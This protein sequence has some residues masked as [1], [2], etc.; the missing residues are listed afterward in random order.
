VAM[1]W[2]PPWERNER[3]ACRVAFD[4]DVE[5]YD[6]ARP[7]PPARV[8]DDLLELAGLQAGSS[9]VEIGPG[10]GQATRPLAMR[11]L[12]I[13]ALELGPQLAARAREN[14]ASFA[15][16]EVLTT[17]FEA[18]DPGSTRVAAVFA[19][20]S[21]HWV[22]PAVRLTKSAAVLHPDG[23]LIVLATPW[24]V[25]D[26]ADRFWWEVQ[27]DYAAIGSER[28]DPATQHPDPR[29]RRLD[30][31]VVGPVRR[32]HDPPT[33]L[34]GHLHRGS[35]RPQPL[36]PVR[37]QGVPARRARR[38][39]RQDPTSRQQPRRHSDRQPPGSANRCETP[40]S[41]AAPATGTALARWSGV[42]SHV[43]DLDPHFANPRATNGAAPVRGCRRVECS[44]RLR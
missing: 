22:D 23:H 36:H 13:L 26:H 34:R 15:D 16:V 19:C 25:P 33:P 8:F 43:T 31:G 11:G 9:I 29:R 21:F 12:R 1:P 35:V 17:S 27:D 32:T 3:D 42:Q 30:P 38:A 14:L 4:E 6:R 39:D 7:I 24:V 5:A 18:W 37:H 40:P 41:L 28:L 20:N 10:T 2:R 44:G